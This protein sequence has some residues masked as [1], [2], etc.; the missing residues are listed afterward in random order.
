MRLYL[1]PAGR[2]RER[3]LAAVASDYVKKTIGTL[4]ESDRRELARLPDELS[5]SISRSLA[6][7][8]DPLHEGADRTAERSGTPPGYAEAAS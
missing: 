5:A 3:E 6:V 4:P 2:D 8:G 7:T 1:T